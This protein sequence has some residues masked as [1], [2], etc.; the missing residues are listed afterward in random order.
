MEGTIIVLAV[1][2]VVIFFASRS[3]LRHLRS[4]W[5]GE[6]CSSCG[7]SCGSCSS[8]CHP[9][10]SDKATNWNEVWADSC[11]NVKKQD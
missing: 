6:G 3:T 5:K 8:G 4:E 11:S 10:K 2:A 7:G 9:A 1:L